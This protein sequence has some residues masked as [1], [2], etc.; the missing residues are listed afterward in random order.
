MSVLQDRRQQ[1]SALMD[2]RNLKTPEMESLVESGEK[3]YSQTSPDGREII[4]QQI[5]T[6]RDGWETLGEQMQSSWQKV[7]H[8]S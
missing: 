3:L 6:V 5:R 4:R 1:L 2:Q 7:G 8:F